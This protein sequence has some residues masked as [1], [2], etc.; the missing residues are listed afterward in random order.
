M[1]FIRRWSTPP[2]NTI[3]VDASLIRS[4]IDDNL[5]L[6]IP[7]VLQDFVSDKDDFALNLIGEAVVEDPEVW[8]AITRVVVAYVITFKFSELLQ[9]GGMLDD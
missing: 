3:V 9:D 8:E 2:R 5:D 6:S 7:E 1:R 4:I